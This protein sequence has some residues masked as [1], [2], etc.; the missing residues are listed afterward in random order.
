MPSFVNHQQILIIIITNFQQIHRGSF[1]KNKNFILGK[2][3]MWGFA[4]D[5]VN[6]QKWWNIEFY[7]KFHR[8]KWI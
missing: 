5:D 2:S 3:R 8:L 1:G 6:G 7:K 4:V